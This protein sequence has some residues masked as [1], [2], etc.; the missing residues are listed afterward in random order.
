MGLNPVED[1]FMQLFHNRLNW[2]DHN[3]DHAWLV[4]STMQIISLFC[5]S[6][7]YYRVGVVIAAA[8]CLK[9]ILATASGS[10]LLKKFG[11]AKQEQLLCYLEPFRQSKKKRA[12]FYLGSHVMLWLILYS[13]NS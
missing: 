2:W 3:E 8:S 1:F 13:Y 7:S 11:E 12:S 10:D 9:K 5:H 4:L 6:C